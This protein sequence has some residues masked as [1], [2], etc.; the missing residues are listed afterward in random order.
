MADT[1]GPPHPDAQHEQQLNEAVRAEL[2]RELLGSESFIPVLLL[3]LLLLALIVLGPTNATT[4][5]ATAILAG[6]IVLLTTRRS[7][8]RPRTRRAMDAAAVA[9]GGLAAVQTI[10]AGR[11]ESPAWLT[12]AGLALLATVTFMSVP[13]VLRRV[14][15]SR[16]VSVNILAGA[17]VAY[18]LIG[19]FFAF[20]IAAVAEVVEPYF[21]ELA[22]PT[23]ADTTYFSFITITTVGYGDLAPA[24]GAARSLAVLEAV[25]GQVFLVTIVARVV[26]NLGAERRLPESVGGGGAV[27][28]DEGRA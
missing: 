15:T 20:S 5:T 8:V 6:T 3:V 22:D 10:A 9:C 25:I 4:R 27:D 17:L 18:L 26:S 2:R 13:A 7:R 16:R 21:V 19:L 28:P 11:W 12:V 24:A 1:P 23:V 14:L